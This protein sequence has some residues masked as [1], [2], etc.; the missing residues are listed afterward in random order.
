MR[1][2]LFL[3]VF[4]VWA[5]VGDDPFGGEPVVAVPIDLHAATAAKKTEAT[6]APEADPSVQAARPH[7]AAATVGAGS[8]APAQSHAPGTKTVTIIDGKTGA[9]QEVVIPDTG[10]AGTSRR[11]RRPRPIRNSSK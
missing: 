5:I 6:P 3:G 4:A 11:P 9:R 1:S 7:D 10:N 2:S 8:P